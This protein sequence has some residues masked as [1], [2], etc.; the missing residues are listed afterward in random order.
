MKAY[1]RAADVVAELSEEQRDVRRRTDSWKDLPGIGPKTATVIRES[2]DGVPVYL[3]ELREN[4]EPIGG[5]ALRDG[6]ER[7]PAHPLGL[8]GRRQPDRRD[9]ARRARALG[10]EYIALTDHSPRLTVANGLSAER[11]RAQLEVVAALN[12]ELA[13]FR[14]LTGIEVDILDDGSLDQE[15]DLLDELDVVVASVHSK[16]R[17]ERGTMTAPDGRR[18]SRIR[19]STCWA[20]APAG[21]SMAARGTGRS[22]RSTPS[23]CSRPAATSARRSR[24]TPGPSGCDPPSR[25]LRPGG[26][27][28]VPVLDR[29]RRARARAARTGRATA[30]SGPM[31]C[32]VDR[33]TA[34]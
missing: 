2:L 20:T 9:G 19:T 18:R 15:P 11:L 7:R 13:P 1:R 24:S 23:R 8:V 22:R 4:A 5:G 29:H 31:R 25:L 28:R 27:E 26:G 10:H 21:S 33:P 14:I 6:A 12:E 3:A 16:L 30:A 17:M 32:G 34:S